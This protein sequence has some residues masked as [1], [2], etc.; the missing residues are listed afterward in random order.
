MSIQWE[1]SLK[2][3]VAAIDEQHEEIFK[4]FST[5]TESLQK[6]E[7]SSVV[8]DMLAY[9]DQ[10]TATHFKDEEVLMELHH[11]PKLELQRQQHS[12]FREN[13]AILSEKVANNAPK[14]E[15]AIKIDAEL[16]KYFITHIRKLDRELVEF[17][18][19]RFA[20]LSFKVKGES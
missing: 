12:R 10:Y 18:T 16:I 13:V 4:H 5:L 11:Y 7:G 20:D 1:E 19:S 2:L 9:L 15:I 14:Q 17:I 3:G 8:L 6:G